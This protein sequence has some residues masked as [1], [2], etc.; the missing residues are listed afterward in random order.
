MHALYEKHKKLSY[1]KQS[2]QAHI[3]LLSIISDMKIILCA[4]H[5]KLVCIHIINVQSWTQVVYLQ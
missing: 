2:H 5:Q 3:I 4:T 1:F